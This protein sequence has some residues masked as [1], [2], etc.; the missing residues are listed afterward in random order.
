MA[1]EI[2][3]LFQIDQHIRK[4]KPDCLYAEKVDGDWK[5]YSGQDFVDITDHLAY[6]LINL[7][8]KKGDKVSVISENRP[9]WMFVDFALTKMTA[10]HVPIYPNITA[11]QIKYILEDAEVKCVFVS[12]QEIYNQVIELKDKLPC[13]E[14]IFVF[15]D[16]GAGTSWTTLL[17][18]GKEN[19]QSSWIK[20]WQVETK[21]E[22]LFTIIYTSGTT[23]NPKGV[24]LSHSNV[25]SQINVVAQKFPLKPEDRS[26]SFLPLCHVF[27]RIAEYYT[28][29]HL[30]GTYYAEAMDK[31]GDNLREVRPAFMC[32]VPR[33][34]EKVYDKIVLKGTQLPIHKKVLFNWALK[35]GKAHE[36]DGTSGFYKFQLKLANKLIF[37]KWREALGGEMRYVVVGAAALQPR[38][39][40]VFNA[41]QIPVFEGYGLSETSPVIAFNSP[42]KGEY[43]YGTVGCV[44]SGGEVKLADDGEILYRG[45]NVMMGYYKLADE[46]LETFDGD[47]L[48]TGDIGEFVDSKFLKITDRKKEVFK[49]SGGKYVSPQCLENKIRESQFIEQVMV[50]GEGEKHPSALVVPYKEF[51][52]KWCEKHEIK[53]QDWETILSLDVVK[54]RLMRVVEESN[55]E[56]SNFMR[57]KKIHLVAE[58]WSVK[59]G[60]LTPTQKMKRRVINEAYKT[61]IAKFYES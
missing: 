14:H 11:D 13:L 32:T 16:F 20:A 12:S 26:L 49:T 5:T 51:L 39:A 4:H 9:Q 18:S 42:I 21:K 60:E 45:P 24:M 61:E 40:R 53:E 31:I 54:N 43:A 28:M 50:V 52:L 38:L 3:K 59:T 23:G 8:L 30:V 15:D 25:C 1:I 35:L 27:Q 33:L 58:T 57:V 47:W 29:S 41:A 22:D 6:G 36:I 46:S 10:I 2:N 55:E 34:L 44:I 7:G 48:K 56:F 37:S 17:D 19:P